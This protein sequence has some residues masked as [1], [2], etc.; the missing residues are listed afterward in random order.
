MEGRPTDQ[1]IEYFHIATQVIVHSSMN[2]TNDAFSKK[3]AWGMRAWL[4]GEMQLATGLRATYILLEK[5]NQRLDR[6]EQ[7]MLRR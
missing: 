5:I 4:M 3:L 6:I 2:D 1:A 7:S